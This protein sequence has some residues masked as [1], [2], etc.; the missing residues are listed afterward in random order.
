VGPGAGLD[1]VVKRKIPSPCRASNPRS[2]SPN[3][4]ATILSSPDS[5]F[6]GT[7]KLKS[8]FDLVPRLRMHGCNVHVPIR[9]YD[10]VISVREK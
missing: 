4:N 1:A 6:R 8:H 5:S 9:L 2:S 3:L 7:M 10:V